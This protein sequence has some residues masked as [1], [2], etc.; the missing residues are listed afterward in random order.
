MQCSGAWRI[1]L[2]TRV[3]QGKGLSISY[4]TAWWRHQMEI[5]SALLTICAGIHRWQ[6][7]HPHKGQWRGA[8]MFSFIC[9]WINGWVNNREACNLRLYR[10]HYDVVV[11]VMSWFVSYS[12]NFVVCST[13]LMA[14]LIRS[15]GGLLNYFYQALWLVDLNAEVTGLSINRRGVA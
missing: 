12:K 3:L 5:F 14:L 8:L 1:T 9:V 6:V 4:K 15:V 7:N 11:M 13:S 2:Q 10:A